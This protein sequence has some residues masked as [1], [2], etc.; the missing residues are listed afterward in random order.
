MDHVLPIPTPDWNNPTPSDA[1]TPEEVQAF[2]ELQAA[3]TAI[4]C[5]VVDAYIRRTTAQGWTALA[6]RLGK[7][8]ETCAAQAANLQRTVTG[9]VEKP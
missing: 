5:P 1:P 3:A 6:E 8:M 9:E 4:H 7:A 2:A